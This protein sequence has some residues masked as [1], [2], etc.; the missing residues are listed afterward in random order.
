MSKANRSGAGDFSVFGKRSTPTTSIN[1]IAGGARIKT[2][3]GEE[4][5]SCGNG[6]DG[7]KRKG[8]EV[9]VRISP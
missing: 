4:F 3:P 2:E 5:Q 9:K 8:N 1:V 7:D 6:R